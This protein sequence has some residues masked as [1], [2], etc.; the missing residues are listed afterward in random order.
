MTCIIGAKRKNGVILV[1]DRLVVRGNEVF[2]TDKIHI[3]WEE[4]PIVAIAF[5]GFTGIRGKFSEYATIGMIKARVRNLTEVINDLEK[6]CS[7]IVHAICS[8]DYKKRRS[9]DGCYHRGFI[10]SS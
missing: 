10:G 1:S 9:Y 5:S 7:S 3:L 8:E 4:D 2:F 6:R